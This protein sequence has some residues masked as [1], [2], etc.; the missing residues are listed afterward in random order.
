MRKIT[1][2]DD[3]TR[4]LL[5]QTVPRRRERVNGFPNI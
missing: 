3:F 2:E 4:P 5:S 1:F